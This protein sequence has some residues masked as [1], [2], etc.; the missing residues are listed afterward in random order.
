MSELVPADRI[1]AIVG[2]P[3][4]PSEHW[5]RAVSAEQ[6]MYVLHSAACLASGVDLRVCRF[7]IALDNGI[8]LGDWDGREDQ[9]VQLTIDAGGRLIPAQEGAR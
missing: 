6:T 9:P 5:G 8:D 3:R 2:I 7:S 4:H 1:E